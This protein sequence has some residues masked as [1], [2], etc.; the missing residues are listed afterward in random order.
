M[1]PNSDASR[2]VDL[3]WI[4]PTNREFGWLSRELAARCKAM[5]QA[6]IHSDNFRTDVQRIVVACENRVSFPDELLATLTKTHADIPIV[7]AFGEWWEG[8]RRTSLIQPPAQAF[9]WHQL[10][11]QWLPWLAGSS[12]RLLEICT[13]IYPATELTTQNN[14]AENAR[15]MVITSRSDLSQSYKLALENQGHQTSCYS[16][17]SL[18]PLD[19]DLA[20]QVV[21]WDDSC[22]HGPGS[23][24]SD[25]AYTEAFV[26]VAASLCELAPDSKHFFCW[27]TA[28]WSLLKHFHEHLPSLRF[29]SK[30]FTCA[31]LQMA[32][33]PEIQSVA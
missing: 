9:N 21:V 12:T 27:N 2:A 32:L 6:H 26:R 24:D 18:V 25:P 16:F 30:P 20:A 4:G 19:V 28:R 5:H 17:S 10:Y 22:L 3:L 29:L 15:A 23:H 8:G 13:S 31:A 7:L 14:R 11:E 33:Q 1:T